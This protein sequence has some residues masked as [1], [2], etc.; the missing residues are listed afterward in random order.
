MYQNNAFCIIFICWEEKH[1]VQY[2]PENRWVPSITLHTRVPPSSPWYNFGH[3]ARDQPPYLQYMHSCRCSD[4]PNIKDRRDSLHYLPR[5]GFPHRTS[6]D[7]YAGE[8][9][10]SFSRSFSLPRCFPKQKLVMVTRWVRRFKTRLP[11]FRSRWTMFFCK[12]SRV[13]SLQFDVQYQYVR[14]PAG[15][16]SGQKCFK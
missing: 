6:G 1:F 14:E 2:R 11:S 15:P 13:C 10:W 5:Y 7:M 16:P 4:C 8:P 9:L 3:P 12:D